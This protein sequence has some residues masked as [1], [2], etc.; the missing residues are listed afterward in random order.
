MALALVLASIA[1]AL[2]PVDAACATSSVAELVY[3][4]SGC[5]CADSVPGASGANAK[6]ER[7]RQQ[8]RMR[9]TE[10]VATISV[11]SARARAPTPGQYIAPIY[12][13]RAPPHHTATI[14]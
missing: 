14:R 7:R 10:L 11:S 2:A 4:V 13:L 12:I 8:E 3:K 9:N 5:C 6:R 1:L